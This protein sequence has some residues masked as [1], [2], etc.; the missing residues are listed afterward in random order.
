LP[1]DVA[2]DVCQEV[3]IIVR[4]GHHHRVQIGVIVQVVDRLP[5][6]N[7]IQRHSRIDGD[8]RG[9]LFRRSRPGSAIV[10]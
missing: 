10:G 5:V 8:T 6:A 9:A 7:P 1:L 2:V 4:D 3:A